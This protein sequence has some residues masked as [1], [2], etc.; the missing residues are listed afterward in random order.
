MP[1]F[2]K[3]ER[4]A[5]KAAGRVEIRLGMGG[6]EAQHGKEE[7]MRRPLDYQFSRPLKWLIRGLVLS[8]GLFVFCYPWIDHVLFDNRRAFA[9]VLAMHKAGAA[10]RFHGQEPF[11][12]LSW[13]PKGHPTRAYCYTASS[14][15]SAATH[16]ILYS[17]ATQG[18]L[19]NK[20]NG[21]AFDAM[22]LLKNLPEGLPS[23]HEVSCDRLLIVSRKSQNTWTTRYY[24]RQR[25]PEEIANI[26]RL[27]Q[28][29]LSW[30]GRH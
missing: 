30:D 14:D 11:L 10:L 6:A 20:E 29:D 9:H 2:K 17:Y 3:Q 16:R 4:E 5:G 23:P 22:L 19:I 7:Q 28:I 21:D 15:G 1:F 18:A 24:N 8:A 27:A 13:F 25:L 12:F 26:L